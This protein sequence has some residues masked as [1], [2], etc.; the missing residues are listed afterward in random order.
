MELNATYGDQSNS[1]SNQQVR[2]IETQVYT[3]LAIAHLLLVVT[4]SLILSSL[5]LHNLYTQA[6]ASGVRP[7]SLLYGILAVTCTIGP[8]SYGIPMDVTLLTYL[9]TA[10]Y[11]MAPCSA[12]TV[13]YL[14]L[15]YVLHM[16]VSFCIGMIAVVQ[17]MV[18][19]LQFKPLVT[20]GRLMLF[21][22]IVV[23]VS[24]VV[25]SVLLSVKCTKESA[26]ASEWKL[27]KRSDAFVA[28]AWAFVTIIPLFATV[29]FSCLTCLKVNKDVLKANK[30]VVR[31]VIWINSLNIVS[32]VVSRFCALL[33]Y[34][35]STDVAK[36][37]NSFFMWTMVATYIVELVY[38]LSLLSI[39]FLH[40]RKQ[41]TCSCVGVSEEPTSSTQGQRQPEETSL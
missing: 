32:N 39:F 30:S 24:V 31:S 14:A 5:V 41:M 11:A 12:Y 6:K 3:A 36:T 21:F 37:Q 40:N 18:L 9:Q 10:S 22:V 4:P 19:H 7:V 13:T 35:A 17:F 16:V 25:N 20:L 34:F 26:H 23:V 38:P 8:I 27:Y 15:Y 1:S 28:M 2:P 33:I 29:L